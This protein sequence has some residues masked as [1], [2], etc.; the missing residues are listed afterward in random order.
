MTGFINTPWCG[1]MS[2]RS[3]E[4]GYNRI[5]RGAAYDH[6]GTHTNAV[7]YAAMGFLPRV[8]AG[9]RW[10]VIPGLKAFVDEVPD[11]R[12]TE[13]DRMLSG[14]IELLPPRPGRPGL[15]VGIEDAAG[16]R[17]FH[18]TY[19]VTGI[20]IEYRGL[21]TRLGLGYASRVLT[22]NRHT[23]DGAFWAVEVAPRRP[24]AV[25]LE[26]DTE[27]WNTSLGIDL[28]FGFRARAALLDLKYGSFGAGWSV[29][30]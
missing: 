18:S 29:S 30:L 7:Y 16:T 19:A 28:G 8:E 27:K 14:R 11:S 20:P 26:Y 13:S 9:L 21:H 2:D 12:L 24:V 10:T 25:S 6:R 3:V 22:A 5:P 1:V 23:L 17:R 15:A 4:V